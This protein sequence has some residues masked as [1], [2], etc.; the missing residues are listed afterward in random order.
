VV[1]GGARVPYLAHGLV[2]V[3]PK[4][5][6]SMGERNKIFGIF[7]YVYEYKA[8]YKLQVFD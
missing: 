5:G 6:A 2:S 3:R 1:G 7:G 8:I 4:I